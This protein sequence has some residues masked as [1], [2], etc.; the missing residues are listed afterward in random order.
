MLTFAEGIAISDII[1]AT[2]DSTLAPPLEDED[3]DCQAALEDYPV[4]GI[5]K[6][7][8]SEFEILLPYAYR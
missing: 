7:L 2:A 5:E 6:G 8:S 3:C 4:P 1:G